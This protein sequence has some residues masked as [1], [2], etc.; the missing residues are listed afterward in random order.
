MAGL[1]ITVLVT[2]LNEAANIGACLES[3]AWAADRLVVD[4]GSTDD[5]PAIAARAGARVITHPYESAARQ[6]NWAL[7]LVQH[8]WV[9]ILDA[10]EQVTPA[11]AASIHA[12]V[13]ADGPLDGYYLRRQS[14]FMGHPIRHCGW[15]RDRVLRLFR[16]ARGRYDDRRVHELLQLDGQAGEFDAPLLHFTYRSFHDYLDKLDRY[17]ERGADD[18]RAAGRKASLAALLCRP[19]ARFLRMYVSQ[20]G[21]L[22]GVPGLMVCGLAAGSVWL[23][24]ARLFEAARMAPGTASTAPEPPA[25]TSARTSAKGAT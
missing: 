15:D 13:E 4:S 6:K 11:L 22:D 1:P 8:P 21:F 7:A 19:P 23:K 5:T 3:V 2:T 12:A 17:T 14:F 16:T 9:L 18:L 10:D 24:Y 25:T 20:R